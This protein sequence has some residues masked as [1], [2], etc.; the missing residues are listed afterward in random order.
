MVGGLVE[1]QQVGL[2]HQR[3]RERHALLQAAGELARS[4]RRA[5]ASS[6]EP[7]ERGLV[8]RCVCSVQPSLGS[9]EHGA[10]HARRGTASKTSDPASNAGSCA[11]LATWAP[12]ASHTLPSSG[13]RAAL[14]DAQQARLAGAVAADEADALARLDHQVGVVE[15]R[16]VAVGEADFGELEQGHRWSGTRDFT[17]A[18]G[19]KRMPE[20]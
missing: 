16:H 4:G 2:E 20:L 6:A 12:G 17:R 19:L 7:L 13:A 11:T 9:C 1:Q 10:A 15:E 18:K 8:R 5:P 14:D 3:A